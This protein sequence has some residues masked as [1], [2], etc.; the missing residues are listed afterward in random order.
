[1][2]KLPMRFQKCF[3][4]TK[5]NLSFSS[6]FQTLLKML[7]VNNSELQISCL[8]LGLA[9][10]L[11]DHQ[12]FATFP[13]F[14][15]KIKKTGVFLSCHQSSKWE[16]SW[17]VHGKQQALYLDV[18]SEHPLLASVSTLQQPSKAHSMERGKNELKKP[19]SCEGR[20]GSNQGMHLVSAP[21]FTGSYQTRHWCDLS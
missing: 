18:N 17:A 10:S 11:C 5:I 21:G 14:I 16:V 13:K 15:C 12:Q 1:M 6:I 9:T 8:G 19:R 4:A 2:K 7:L 20:P 3:F